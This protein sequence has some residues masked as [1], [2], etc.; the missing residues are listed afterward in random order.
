MADLP[1]VQPQDRSNRPEVRNPVLA[2]PQFQR[3]MDLP[4]ETREALAAFLYGIAEA[5][6]IK[7]NESW[8]RNKAWMAAYWRVVAVYARHTARALGRVKREQMAKEAD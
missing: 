1:L 4:P 2:I 3:L 8:R 7:G 5:A 6:R